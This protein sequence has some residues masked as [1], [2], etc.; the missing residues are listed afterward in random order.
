MTFVNK[1]FDTNSIKQILIINYK[2]YICQFNAIIRSAK[3]IKLRK[4]KFYELTRARQDPFLQRSFF[5]ELPIQVYPICFVYK[6][7]R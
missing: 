4:N 5:D 6:L 7:I 3:T 2:L 1:K